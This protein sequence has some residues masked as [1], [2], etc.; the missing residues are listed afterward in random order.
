MVHVSDFICETIGWLKLSNKLI[1]EQLKLPEEL[2]LPSVEA[3]KIIYPEKGF[4]TWWDLPQLL[5]QIKH[6]LA[7]FEHTHPDCVGI[8]VFDRSSAHE[9]YADNALNIN[10]MN[11]NP[12]GK[13]KK[14]Q[15]TRIPLNNPGPAPGE[16]DTH[17]HI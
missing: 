7:V 9:G 5:Q 16:E 8:W 6:A 2:R 10:S 3:R 11:I 14:L 15:D 17:G 4:D 1:K 12:G 13:Q